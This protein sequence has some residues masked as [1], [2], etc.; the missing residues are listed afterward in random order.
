MPRTLYSNRREG[1]R[2]CVWVGV[3]GWGWGDYAMMS[4]KQHVRS[5]LRCIFGPFNTRHGGNDDE[6]AGVQYCADPDRAGAGS[7]GPVAVANLPRPVATRQPCRLA[8]DSAS[9]GSARVRDQDLRP[10]RH[11][12]KISGSHFRNQNHLGSRAEAKL[13][14]KRRKSMHAGRRSLLPHHPPPSSLLAGRLGR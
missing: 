9:A 13:R 14:L 3:G 11:S 7:G 6:T 12:K 2:V 5:G 8:D 4:A 10:Y 1:V